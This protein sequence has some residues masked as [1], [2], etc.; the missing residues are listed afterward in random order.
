M[1][2]LITDWQHPL[3]DSVVVPEAYVVLRSFEGY[4]PNQRV[5]PGTDILDRKMRIDYDVFFSA[6]DYAARKQPIYTNSFLTTNVDY[7]RVTRKK[8]PT[9]P[10]VP[11]EGDDPYAPLR[12]SASICPGTFEDD[13]DFV[14]TEEDPDNCL[15]RAY[16]ALKWDLFAQ[17]FPLMTKVP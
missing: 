12:A 8:I 17:G 9:L 7:Y 6:A 3:Y 5:L 2:G 15:M 13:P 11:E 14:D 10:P 16:I 4:A 1:A